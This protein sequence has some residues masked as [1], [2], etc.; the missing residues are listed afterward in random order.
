MTTRMMTA[1]TVAMMLVGGTAVRAPAR[2]ASKAAAANA[3]TALNA[4]KAPTAPSGRVAKAASGNMA[5]SSAGGDR[6]VAR[7]RPL[8]AGEGSGFLFAFVQP[9]AAPEE[10]RAVY[11]EVEACAGLKGNYD[12]VKWSVIP[13][14]LQGL[15]GPTYA[16]TIGNRIVLVR[17]DTTYLRHEMLHHILEVSGWHPRTLRPGEQYSIAELHPKSVFGRCTGGR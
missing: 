13:E 1:V 10:W 4:V 11:A 16:F 2:H 7:G 6:A 12:A 9:V 5:R 17:N 8:R 3:A 14:P 15:K